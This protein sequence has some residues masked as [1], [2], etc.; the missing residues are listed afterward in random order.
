[1]SC[2]VC[3]IT[4]RAIV[5]FLPVPE[6]GECAFRHIDTGIDI[7]TDFDIDIAIDN[8]RASA[9]PSPSDC[10]AAVP[11]HDVRS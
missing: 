1:M 3:A 9:S 5:V 6:F 7:D 11:M 2:F 10:V 8:G 4:A